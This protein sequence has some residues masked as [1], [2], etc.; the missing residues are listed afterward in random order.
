MEERK[1]KTHIP[2]TLVTNHGEIILAKNA[3]MK[4][5]EMNPENDEIKNLLNKITKEL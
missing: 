1:Q 4:A 2:E 3:L 5:Q